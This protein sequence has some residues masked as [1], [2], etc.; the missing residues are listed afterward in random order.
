MRLLCEEGAVDTVLGR[1][2]A[3]RGDRGHPQGPQ[4]LHASPV[5]WSQ[6][7]RQTPIAQAPEAMLGDLSSQE[8]DGHH[9]ASDPA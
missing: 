5:G 1:L 2:P 7:S 8:A 9:V 4:K 3:S 6:K